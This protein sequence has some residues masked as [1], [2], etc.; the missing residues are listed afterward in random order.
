MVEKDIISRIDSLLCVSGPGGF[1]TA[2][3]HHFSSHTETVSNQ[4]IRADVFYFIFLVCGQASS[5][6][7][8]FIFLQ[9]YHA[10]DG[11]GLS[12]LCFMRYDILEYFSIYGTALSIW[13]SLMGKQGLA[14]PAAP[15]IC[16][17]G[18]EGIAGGRWVSWVR[19]PPISP[20]FP[21]ARPISLFADVPLPEGH[22]VPTGGTKKCRA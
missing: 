6:L 17:G 22:P 3:C 16:R 13:V 5:I 2:Q 15:D 8:P 20:H 1:E 11:P 12:V 10:C 9:I 7:M 4:P 19:K 21:R 14:V 18:S